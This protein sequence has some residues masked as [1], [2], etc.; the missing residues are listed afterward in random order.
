M[1]PT[2]ALPAISVLYKN[3]LTLKRRPTN[4]LLTGAEVGTPTPTSRGRDSQIEYGRG[5]RP[6]EILGHD[7]RDTSVLGHGPETIKFK[8]R[9][10]R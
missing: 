9:D 3:D 5:T 8:T 6:H 2:A 4:Y 1:T 10:F 7:P